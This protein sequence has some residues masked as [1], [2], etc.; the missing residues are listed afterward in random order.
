MTDPPNPCTRTFWPVILPLVLLYAIVN[1][2]A[3]RVAWMISE[4]SEWE[5]W[6]QIIWRNISVAFMASEVAALC[7]VLVFAPGRF[8]RRLAPCWGAGA[9]LVGCWVIGFGTNWSAHEALWNVPLSL[10]LAALVVQAPLWGL[11]VCI[12]WRWQRETDAPPTDEVRWSLADLFVG[13]ALFAVSLGLARL[14]DPH[15]D[16]GVW[17]SWVHF[18]MYAFVFSLFGVGPAMYLTLRGGNWGLGALRF[19]AYAMLAGGFYVAIDGGPDLYFSIYGLIP[20]F[21]SY[22]TGLLL[23]TLVARRLGYR[24]VWG[25]RGRTPAAS[26]SR[27]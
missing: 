1:L 10:P 3:L 19:L 8:I 24:L 25:H 17:V 23:A 26:N 27:P 15:D 12:G 7:M 21:L 16:N 22:A 5:E 4:E 13:M 2:C 20:A 6:R 18:S 14:V 11:R 9:I